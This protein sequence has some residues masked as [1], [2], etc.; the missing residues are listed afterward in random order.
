MVIHSN[1][2]ELKLA[3]HF[4]KLVRQQPWMIQEVLIGGAGTS[5]CTLHTLNS[6]MDLVQSLTPTQRGIA[7]QGERLWHRLCRNHGLFSHQQLQTID[8]ADQRRFKAE[9]SP[10]ST[11]CRLRQTATR[12]AEH[13]IS[14]LYDCT[15]CWYWGKNRDKRA[16]FHILFSDSVPTET[17]EED[18]LR[19]LKF[20][21]DGA[22]ATPDEKWPVTRRNL[23][24]LGNKLKEQH[25]RFQKHSDIFIGMMNAVVDYN[26]AIQVLEG[27]PSKFR[28]KYL[29]TR[30]FQLSTGTTKTIR[31]ESSFIRVLISYSVQMT[32]RE[33]LRWAIFTTQK[34]NT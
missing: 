16:N 26:A 25:V 2:M 4:L 1:A 31:R 30:T 5:M 8:W 18:F 9:R 14:L 12:L 3:V 21:A 28:G 19:E 34:T 22:P 17:I 13:R 24:A 20:S 29:L 11:I 27:K 10:Q 23:E 6:T 33:S 32:I 15:A 7:R